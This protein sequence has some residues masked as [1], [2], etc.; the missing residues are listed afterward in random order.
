M[1]GS[2]IFSNDGTYSGSARVVFQ[3]PDGEV[4][5]PAT[6]KVTP[7]GHVTF[8]IHIQQYSIPPEYRNYLPPFLD[9]HVA[10]HQPDGSI[11]SS[12]SG[13]QKIPLLEAQTPAGRFQ[14]T[15]GIVVHKTMSLLPKGQ[16]SITVVANDL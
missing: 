10:E 3:A 4:S 15:R 8:E 12:D 14:G 2:W 6:I 13:T 16:A 7:D 1:I 11:R 9:G 5:G